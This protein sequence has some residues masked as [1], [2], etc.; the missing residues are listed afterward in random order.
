MQMPN[1]QQIAVMCDIAKSGGAGLK[2]ERLPD[3]AAL[4][5]AGHVERT[6]DPVEAYALTGKGQA[7]LDERGVG[8]NES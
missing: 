8:V 4:V 1:D 6:S 7:F 3:V 2:K 5:A